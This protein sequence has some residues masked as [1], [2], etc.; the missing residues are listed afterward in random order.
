MREIKKGCVSHDGLQSVDSAGNWKVGIESHSQ[1]LE[2]H[3]AGNHSKVRNVRRNTKHERCAFQGRSGK[4]SQK[5]RS[6]RWH[7]LRQRQKR[8]ISLRNARVFF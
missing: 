1:V 5:I 8:D 7:P 3:D 4:R 6:L 2:G